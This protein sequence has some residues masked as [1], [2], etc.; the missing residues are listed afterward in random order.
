MPTPTAHCQSNPP[1][2]R[3]N[4]DACGLK[5][6]AATKGGWIA[7]RRWRS[8]SSPQKT[9]VLGQMSKH[10]N[11]RLVKIHRSYT[12]EEIAILLNVHKNT[13]RGWVKGGLPTVDRQRPT[14]ILGHI[15]SRYLQDRRLRGKKRCA[16]G[17]IYC[18]KCRAPVRPAG[19]MADYIPATS[20]SGA[21]TGIC[22]ACE[23]LIYRRV[24]QAT[25]D[26]SRGYLD[27]TIPQARSH[28]RDS[29]SLSV[30]C[31]SNGGG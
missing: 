24:S 20:T 29:Q 7:F 19:G 6:R 28:I 22:P 16:P 13:V 26:E 2:I 11:Y 27:I 8:G 14:L 4:S 12:I 10:T 17:E 9:V 31:D 21:L 3:C 25:L 15:L 18:V 5:R 30:N 23:T 1:S